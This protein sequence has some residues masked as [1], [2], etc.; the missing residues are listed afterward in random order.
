MAISDIE[1]IY[2]N[3]FESQRQNLK[4]KTDQELLGLTSQENQVNNEYQTLVNELAN[5]RKQAQGEYQT[6]QNQA[7]VGNARNVAGIRDWM[8][9]NNL[10][11][12]GENVDAI[13]RANTDYGNEQG[14]IKGAES[15]YYTGLDM[16]RG[17]AD[18][19]K[20]NRLSDIMG[21]R[22]L[23]NN[24]FNDQVM[25]LQ[26]EMEAQKA[27]ELL[28]YKQQQEAIARQQAAAR[29]TRTSGGS[30]SSTSNTKDGIRS[31]FAQLMQDPNA[32][33]Y[34]WLEGNRNA[35]IN[36]LGE[37]EYNQMRAMFNNYTNAKGK[38]A[39]MQADINYANSGAPT[40]RPTIVA[41]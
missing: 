16:Q 15:Q 41:Y 37:T 11:Q 9:K 4:N 19:E 26:K 3:M 10:L 28:Q 14:R 6:Q 13:L 20:A 25:A 39:A 40:K 23:I 29:A 38:Q 32:N 5:R 17:T 1:K 35:L 34:Q 2:Q 12:S 8:A 21:K 30:R 7:A 33:V 31:Q 22:N 36:V 18:R 27:R 24:S